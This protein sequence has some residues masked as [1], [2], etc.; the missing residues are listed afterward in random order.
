MFVYILV[1]LFYVIV[2][3]TI[4]LN[5]LS[6]LVVSVVSKDHTQYLHLQISV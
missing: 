4:Q 5:I 6:A 2:T 3:L 1:S